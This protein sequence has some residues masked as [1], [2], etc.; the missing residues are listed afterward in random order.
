MTPILEW[1]LLDAAAQRDALAR[2]PRTRSREI[3]EAVAAIIA[4]I[5]ARGDA[6]VIE[7]SRRHDGSRRDS[8]RAS[9]GELE[10]ARRRVPAEL[11]EA[12]EIAWSNIHRFHQ[13]G[14]PREFALETTRGVTCRTRFSPISRI[15]LYAP[16]GATPLPSSVMMTGIPAQIAGCPTRLLC[17]PPN[18]QGTIDP[19]TAWAAWKCCIENVFLVGGAHAI[20]AMAFGTGSI[21]AVD[22]LFGPGGPWV[23]LAKQQI[24]AGES[25]VSIDMAAG[26]SEVLILADDAARPA[27]VAVDMLAQLEH[28]P[29]SQAILVT[30]SRHLAESVQT[31]LARLSN[32][33]SRSEVIGQSLEHSR[34]I[35]AGSLPEAT[36]IANRYAPEHLIIQTADAEQMSDEITA[37]GCI[38]LGP[39]TPEVLGDYCSG[40]N[41]VL[42]TSGYARSCQGLSVA[43]FMKRMTIQQA[44]RAGFNRLAPVASALARWEGLTAHDLAITTRKKCQ[45]ADSP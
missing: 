26:P 29:D 9:R 13:A 28:G 32:S 12:L 33:L 15:G 38:F 34:M 5:R 20:A 19:A 18:E 35:L 44:D 41:H 25:G 24:A 4:D 10:E 6:A 45:E 17:T 37:A 22:K 23:T 43:D 8:L 42:P 30:T 11:E 31:E 27:F 14:A 21:P 36:E 2:A 39:W 16:G 3:A 7:L 1:R 40:T